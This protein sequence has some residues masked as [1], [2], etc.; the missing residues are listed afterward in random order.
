MA[1]KG[2]IN[3]GAAKKTIAAL[4]AQDEEP[5]A[6]IE[7][8]GLQQNNDEAQLAAFVAQALEAHPDMVEGYRKGKLTL[9]KALMGAAMGLSGGMANPVLLQRLMDEALDGKPAC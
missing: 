8:M 5:E 1:E 7:R 6:Y 4:W 3:S 2:I 9:K